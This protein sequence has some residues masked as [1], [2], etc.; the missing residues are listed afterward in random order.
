MIK[1]DLAIIGAGPV[2][3]FTAFQAG[4]LGLKSIIIDSLEF[5]GGQCA[6]LYPEKPIY[7][8]PGFEHISGLELIENLYRQAKPFNPHLL[9]NNTVS[10][11][12]RE[13]GRWRLK[14]SQDMEIEVSAI[15]IAAGGGAFG[16]NKP[17]LENIES[18]E[19][20]SVFYMVG[21]M[22]DFRDKTVVIA[23]GGDSAVDW[24]IILSSIAKKVYVVHRRDKFRALPENINKM[25][26]I[27]KTGKI[28]F[29]IPYQLKALHGENGYLK[30]IEVIDLDNNV[31][32]IEADILLPF[33]GLAMEL[34]AIAD[35]GLNFDKKHIAVDPVNMTTNLENIYAVGDVA[36]YKGKLKLILT[37]FSEAALACH[38]VYSVVYPN[39]PLHFEYSTTKGIP[40]I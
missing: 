27:S 29:V 21:K 31:R 20:K 38:S 4:M 36:T 37:G 22:E 24:T 8:I 28:E 15:I 7:D 19:G 12:S 34:G 13:N 30:E 23:G 39:K 11:I 2:G 3:L 32:T 35:W 26:E 6:A 25:H 16:A 5:M 10:H 40:K 9:L 1:S 17:P 18:F 14:T 33:F